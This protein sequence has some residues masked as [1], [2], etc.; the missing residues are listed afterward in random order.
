VVEVISTVYIKMGTPL[1][2]VNSKVAYFKL[3]LNPVKEV[4]LGVHLL[5]T[6][7]VQ[8]NHLPLFPGFGRAFLFLDKRLNSSNASK[9]RNLDLIG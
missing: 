6:L 8:S 5:V 2:L 3:I 4:G 7:A 1:S 9:A